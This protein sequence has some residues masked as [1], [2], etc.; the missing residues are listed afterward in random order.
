M[1]RAYRAAIVGTGGIAHAHAQALADAGR[2]V[3]L[4]HAIDV[5]QARATA[6]AAQWSDGAE[7]DGAIP[8][9]ASTDLADVLA[10][11]REAGEPLDLVHIC[12]PPQSHFVLAAQVLQAGVDVLLEK[13]PTLSLVE[14]D[15]LIAI[16]RETG[17]HVGVVFQHRFGAGAQRLRTLIEAAPSPIGRPL[18]AL[19]NTLW[20][21]D[22]EYFAA[23]WRGRWDTEGGGPTMGHGIH[24]F[25]LLL[26]V[27]GPWA[28]V[29]AMAGR[30]ARD[31]DTEDASMAIVRFASGALATIVNSVV[32]PRQTS[33]LRFDTELATIEL[34]HLYGYTDADWTFTPAPGHE[35]LTEL[36]TSDPDA[37]A[38]SHS[39]QVIAILDALDAG[40]P[41][42]VTA[43][44]ARGTI[45][46]VAALY[47]SAFTGRPIRRGE[48]D[49]AHPF[50]AAMNGTGAPW[51]AQP[52]EAET[53]APADVTPPTPPAS[54]ST[55]AP[56]ETR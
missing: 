48:I 9:L 26:S 5:D 45:E 36:W 2:R 54:S 18:V 1:T 27:L 35:E 46:L 37:A 4:T 42:P 44:D 15:E 55:P 8:V 38:S 16:E 51:A 41:P 17:A 21:R 14:L 19:C 6:F 50:A 28:E 7:P 40:Q 47:A 30:Q 29:T 34:E 49:A 33:S 12:T 43:T 13:P 23:P 32:S 3:R 53:S 22:A 10:R 25:D 11:T 31:T 39:S 52:A 20:Y 24:Q 56:E